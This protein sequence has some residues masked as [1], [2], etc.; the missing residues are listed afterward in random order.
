[1]SRLKIRRDTGQPD[2]MQQRVPQRF[3]PLSEEA[4]IW[5]PVQALLELHIQ[6]GT[7]SELSHHSPGPQQLLPQ[8]APV[9]QLVHDESGPHMCP[10]PP[11]VPVPPVP[12]VTPPA[13]A[14][15]RSEE[16]TSELQ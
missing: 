15:P 1:M 16:H 14:L 3:V 9:A 5:P 10:A 4:H 11:P 2:P 8:H 7:L 6:R 13:P 12:P